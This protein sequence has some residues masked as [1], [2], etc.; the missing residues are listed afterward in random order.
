MPN[1][2][3][4]GTLTVM[5]CQAPPANAKGTDF[6]SAGGALGSS[7]SILPSPGLA[8]FTRRLTTAGPLPATLTPRKGV[9]VVPFTVTMPSFAAASQPRATQPWSG[10]AAAATAFT[11]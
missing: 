3:A 7:H 5:S 6:T 1:G 8:A 10:P 9:G 11:S 2:P 4:A